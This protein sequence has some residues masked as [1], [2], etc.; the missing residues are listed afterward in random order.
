MV[1]VLAALLLVVPAGAQSID[2]AIRAMD[3]RRLDEAAAILANVVRQSPKDARA[4]KLL[5]IAAT[6]RGDLDGAGE[7]LQKACELAPRDEE[8]CYFRARNLH[9]VGRFAEAREAFEK[10]LQAAPKP[11]LPKVHRAVALNYVALNMT[12]DA[13]RHFRKAV[14]LS[15]NAGAED[16]RIDYGV[17]LFRQ[18]RSTAALEQLEAAVRDQPSSARANME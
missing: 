18:G 17:F 9:V 3:A 6:S 14:Q 15:R 8:A 7:A 13:E 4:W 10:A 5:G 1:A 16:P 2:E 11:M 12:D